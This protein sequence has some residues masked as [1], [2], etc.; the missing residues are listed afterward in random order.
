MDERAERTAHAHADGR[1]VAFAVR[2]GGPGWCPRGARGAGA[3]LDAF[4]RVDEPLVRPRVAGFDGAR[5]RLAH[6]HRP[7]AMGREI[8]VREAVHRSPLEVGVPVVGHVVGERDRQRLR[9]EVPVGVG[10]APVA[11]QIEVP[12]Q[13][14]RFVADLVEAGDVLVVAVALRPLA[15]DAGAVGIEVGIR[16]DPAVRFACSRRAPW[17][18]C[19]RR[20]PRFP[21]AA[22]R[23]RVPASA[24]PSI[25]WRCAP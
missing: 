10:I 18:S 7:A 2:G 21:R 25:R 4:R 20:T 16:E 19:P 8:G 11:P 17:R 9:H 6:A 15:Q 12:Q 24:A 1:H 23:R 22:I 13:V 14:Q 5:Q 3:R